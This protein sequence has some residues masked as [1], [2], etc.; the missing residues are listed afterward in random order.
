MLDSIIKSVTNEI[1]GNLVSKVG[2]SKDQASKAIETTGEATMD[3]VASQLKSGDLSTVM[4]LFS[5]K[6]NNA[7][8]NGLQNQISNAIAE[9]L[10]GKMGLSKTQIQAIISMALP[11]VMKYVTKKNEETP[12]DDASPLMDIFGDSAQ[13]FLKG[14]AGDLLGKLF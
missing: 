5:S 9:K 3:V 1:G 7:S 14:G 4:N 13:K 6:P 10:S 12:E 8:A 11:V 2:L